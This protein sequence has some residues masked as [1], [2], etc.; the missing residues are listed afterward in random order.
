VTPKST[1]TFA[2]GGQKPFREKVSGLPKAFYWDGL[3][4]LFFI[5]FLRVTSWLKT[6]GGFR[7]P[8]S[9]V[10]FYEIIRRAGKPRPY[11]DI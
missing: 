4:T 1:T 10:C 2:S 9:T 11:L 6:G 3:D 8:K 7:A 5:V